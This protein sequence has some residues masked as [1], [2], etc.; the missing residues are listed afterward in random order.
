M[1]SKLKESKDFFIY[2]GSSLLNQLIPFLLLPILTTYL[3]VKDYG[4]LTLFQT[5][6]AF[7]IPIVSMSL[8]RQL[9]RYFFQEDKNFIAKLIFQIL[10]IFLLMSLFLT[11]LI[12]IVTYYLDINFSKNWLY[13]L[14]IMALFF[15]INSLFMVLLRDLKKAKHYGVFVVFQTVINL[16]VS[17][18]LIVEFH[19]NYEGRF[20]GMFV[21]LLST[22]VFTL[23]YLYKNGWLI[24]KFDFDL[25]KKIYLVSY[26]MIFFGLATIVITMSDILF[27]KQMCSI[28]IVGIYSIALLFGK[29]IVIVQNSV[30]N[31]SEPWFFSQISK[32]TQ[33]AKLEM[34]GFIFFYHVVVIVLVFIVTYFS[35]F[36]IDIMV[37][38]KFHE[39]KKFVF[40]IML[41]YAIKGL[42]NIYTPF[43]V[44]KDKT[45]FMALSTVFSA[46]LNI[47]L[48]YYLILDYGAIGAAYATCITFFF[49]YILNAYY[50]QK[51]YPLMG[52]QH[53]K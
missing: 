12:P 34:L 6:L 43:L 40:I 8:S 51:I 33:N 16:T 18:L 47:I 29:S 14:I 31:V 19:Y 44:H 27:L 20:I 9:D 30:T 13:I 17:I 2:F 50:T 38:E 42:Q 25:F 7:S 24:F 39:A 37:D 26:P 10:I 32:N 22:T 15:S 4:V 21:A 36:A 3:S 28:E 11:I 1:I 45:K 35:Y 46:S 52:L 48:N 23:Y 5:L 53:D 41:A 49:S